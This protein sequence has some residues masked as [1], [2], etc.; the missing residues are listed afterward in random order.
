MLQ[1][2]TVPIP[3]SRPQFNC[4]GV[5]APFLSHKRRAL[6]DTTRPE[7]TTQRART[8][9]AV[10][11]LWFPMFLFGSAPLD[12]SGRTCARPNNRLVSEWAMGL[13]RQFGSVIR[14]RRTSV[15][16]EVA[17]DRFQRE[18][19]TDDFG[20]G[21]IGSVF[22]FNRN[23]HVPGWDLIAGMGLR[24]RTHRSPDAARHTAACS[25]APA[26]PLSPSRG[27]SLA[28]RPP[29]RRRHA[30]PRRSHA[31]HRRPARHSPAAPRSPLAGAAAARQCPARCSHSRTR[32]RG[33]HPL[34]ARCRIS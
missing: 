9:V 13:N 15:L 16:R 31:Q 18:G 12:G 30:R 28:S 2:S 3:A 29:R 10:V 21:F 7:R 32:G 8:H 27:P 33:A 11:V 4:P 14:L 1:F 20:F 19:E 34:A 17:T 5:R 22:G 6:F 25:S 23:L 24:V 26:P